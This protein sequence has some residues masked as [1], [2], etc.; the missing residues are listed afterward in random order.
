MSWQDA[1]ICAGG[2]K[3]APVLNR[4]PEPRLS[5][6]LRRLW[7]ASSRNL[8]AHRAQRMNALYSPKPTLRGGHIVLRNLLK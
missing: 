6:S 3:L 4:R 2:S 1:V 7:S 8:L 5:R